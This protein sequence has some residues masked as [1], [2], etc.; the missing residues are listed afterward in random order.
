[1]QELGEV[2][3][4]PQ[5]VDPFGT[6][7]RRAT[8]EP[9]V[10]ET[11]VGMKRT[12]ILHVG[13]GKTGTSAI[14]SWLA[15]NAD[16]LEEA[17]V[18][19]PDHPSFRFAKEGITTSGNCSGE[20]ADLFERVERV[21]SEENRPASILFSNENLFWRLEEIAKRA[22]AMS[23]LASFKVILF[24]R[25]PVDMLIS[26]YHQRIKNEGETG[27]FE[28]FALRGGHLLHAQKAH[29]LISELG[30]ESV[31]INY[32]VRKK[33]I[34]AAFLEA[35][36]VGELLSAKSQS[37]GGLKSINRSLSAG[38][39]E[40]LRAVN[41]V[42]GAEVGLRVSSRLIELCPDVQPSR[43]AISADILEALED[44][45]RESIAYFN[46]FLL[47]KERLEDDFKSHLSGENQD[48]TNFSPGQLDAIARAL[49]SFFLE[50]NAA[51]AKGKA[52]AEDRKSI[53][54]KPWLHLRRFVTKK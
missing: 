45:Y 32:S 39:L 9:L 16:A 6:T 3:P 10:Q 29:A 28:D 17:G 33:E 30:L 37:T 19:Y 41:R 5:G 40:L 11:G 26:H 47:E 15:T 1:M 51:V 4:Q 54:H 50:R 8:V 31:V 42:S 20:V 43:Q 2:I 36:G 49:N 14:Q 21:L 52:T 46:G 34:L 35:I 53:L 25:D 24:V 13:H 12:V 27:S 7:F 44:R 48:A 38:E 22:H 18:Y 23:D